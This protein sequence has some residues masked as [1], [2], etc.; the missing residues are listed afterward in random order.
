MSILKIDTTL[1]LINN[2]RGF[3]NTAVG[4][5]T[6]VETLGYSTIGDGGGAQWKRTGNLLTA[7]KSPAQ[8]GDARLSDKGSNEWA[9]V[10]SGTINVLKLGADNTTTT[11]SY[12]V[13]LAAITALSSGGKVYAPSGEYRLGQPLIID[14]DGI[15]IYGDGGGSNITVTTLY[16]YHELGPVVHFRRFNPALF[17]LNIDSSPARGIA[18]AGGNNI[19]FLWEPADTGVLLIA[20]GTFK[21]L[22]V[23]DQPDSG[24]VI[25]AGTRRGLL[26]QI[27]SRNNGGHAGAVTNGA[28]TSR[29]NISNVGIITINN[30]SAENCGGHALSIGDPAEVSAVPFRIDVNNYEGSDCAFDAAVR[31]SNAQLYVRGHN[32]RSVIS[33]WRGIQPASQFSGGVYASGVNL[34]FINTR[35]VDTTDCVTIQTDDF[36]VRGV[37]IDGLV[38]ENNVI[39]ANQA[40]A[41]ILPAAGDARGVRVWAQVTV[42]TSWI[43]NLVGGVGPGLEVYYNEDRDI[44]GD[45][46][47][48][49]RLIPRLLS[50]VS[51]LLTD[52]LTTDAGAITINSTNHRVINEGGAAAGNLL[53]ILGGEEGDIICLSAGTSSQTVI[54]NHN[55]A[56]VANTISCGGADINLDSSKDRLTL[57]YSGGHWIMLS[58]ADNGV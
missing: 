18:V 28:L 44:Y 6:I 30:C 13:F 8:L 48:Q 17:D 12:Y 41:I 9:L 33:A 26:D 32:I 2:F 3:T 55:A 52:L 34:E 35:F 58:Y 42:N 56:G 11:D 15:T 49:D 36:S 21:R 1:E 19:G 10:H 47:Y 20:D 22:G 51:R 29:V 45:T 24:W 50:P 39:G 54:V 14:T 4:E 23:F 5:G 57:E 25:S 7:S 38:V 27:Y 43:D 37:K 31:H 40:N 16:G 53:T 46:V